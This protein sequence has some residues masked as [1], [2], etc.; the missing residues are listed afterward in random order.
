M[1]VP[2]FETLYSLTRQLCLVAAVWLGCAGGVA[3]QSGPPRIGIL[4]TRI[5]PTQPV[6]QVF[7]RV[8]KQQGWEP[9]RN[10]LLENL[11]SQ[12]QN[13]DFA[14]E[15]Q[16]MV[17]RKVDVIFANSAPSMHAAYAA[18]RTIPIV[19]LDYTTDPVRQG[20][21]ESY[22]RPGR[23]VT[24]VFLDAPQFAGKWLEILRTL[25]PRLQHVAVLWDPSPGTVHV[26]GLK[27][28]AKLLGLRLKIHTVSNAQDIDQA[29]AAMGP[30]TQALVQLPSPL[31]YAESARVGAM[32]RERQ[33]LGI[34]IWRRFAE[35]GG[36][37]S[38]G[39][40]FVESTERATIMV[41][42]LLRGAKV[43]EMPIERPMRFE[44]LLNMRTL[45][46]LRI[47]VPEQYLVGAEQVN[48]Q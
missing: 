37:V 28:A 44:F 24:G 35:G 45:K 26:E 33:I 4:S 31:M 40:N 38:Y 9:G 2:S 16:E 15:A 19:A 39:P 20:Y 17:R 42:R 25:I 27:A 46:S 47:R 32:T 36:A 10:V 43:S 41:S 21:V 18:T 3:G 29:F 11:P 12:Q 23:N 22:A 34:A 13:A 30:D 48:T 14:A 5:G 8:L 7:E 6:M 1:R